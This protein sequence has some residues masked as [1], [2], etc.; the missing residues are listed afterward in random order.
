MVPIQSNKKGF[1]GLLPGYVEH[2]PGVMRKIVHLYIKKMKLG[3]VIQFGGLNIFLYGA[4]ANSVMM[5]SKM[6]TMAATCVFGMARYLLMFRAPNCTRVQRF[7]RLWKGEW[8]TSNLV[9]ISTVYMCSW[10]GWENVK[11]RLSCAPVSSSI[12]HLYIHS[13]FSYWFSLLIC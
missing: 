8:F 5:E 4:I 2:I 11:V 1:S 3:T 13:W 6:A 12:I 10:G 9:H 7:M